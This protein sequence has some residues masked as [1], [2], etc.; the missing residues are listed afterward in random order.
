MGNILVI[1]IMVFANM[2]IAC[3]QK[4]GKEKVLGSQDRVLE[5]DKIIIGESSG[6]QFHQQLFLTPEQ[7]MC[8]ASYPNLKPEN[9]K[10]G[11]TISG[12]EGTATEYPLCS[13][14]V[15]TG[16]ITSATFPAIDTQGLAAKI[17][18]GQTIGGVSGTGIAAIADCTVGG[19]S[20]C[21]ATNTFKSM[22]LSAK[23]SG[24]A[25]DI[26]NS[27]FT[28]RVT[29]SS[30]FEYWDENGL[31]HTSWP[32]GIQT[33]TQLIP[34]QQMAMMRMLMWKQIVMAPLR[35]P[36]IKD[37]LIAYPMGR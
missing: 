25:L 17:V 11:V 36:L 27:S 20:D 23:D 10:A 12:V 32:G 33:I 14:S 8:V 7:E 35:V 6:W 37:A 16:C 24:G 28:T 29:N 2:Q 26:T 4:P 22:D 3:T 9:I 13:D 34:V 18:V 19:Q 31:R 1:F 15:K 5:K 21:I 30:T